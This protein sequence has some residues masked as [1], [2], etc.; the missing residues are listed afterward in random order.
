MEGSG[1][2]MMSRRDDECVHSWESN[3][4]GGGWAGVVI[5]VSRC[6]RCKRV[7]VAADF[8]VPPV[9]EGAPTS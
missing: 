6:T 8:I 5:G 4:S 2:T 9:T 7:S 1:I 3:G